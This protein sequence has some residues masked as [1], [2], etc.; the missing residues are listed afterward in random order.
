MPKKPASASKPASTPKP[1]AKAPS[2]KPP[3]EGAEAEA[4]NLKYYKE[5]KAVID[6][7][8]QLCNG[9]LKT[10]NDTRLA[11]QVI[12]RLMKY[13]TLHGLPKTPAVHGNPLWS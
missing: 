11:M 8:L 13:Y 3:K 1:K 10:L 5:N 2:K 12:R 4:E 6:K 7:A 9:H